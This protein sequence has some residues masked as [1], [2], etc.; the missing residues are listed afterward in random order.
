MRC[1]R[2]RHPS[3]R[4]DRKIRR[5]FNLPPGARVFPRG[6]FITQQA[7]LANLTAII[8]NG[9]SVRPGDR[10][11]SWLPFY[12]DMG[13]VGLLLATMAAQLSVDFLKHMILPSVQGCG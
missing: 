13:L 12:H 8:E 10:A 11:M 1:L 6:V 5:T 3:F 2:I 9:L 7:V 4:Q